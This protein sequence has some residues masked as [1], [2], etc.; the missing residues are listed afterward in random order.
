M[1]HRIFFSQAGCLLLIAATLVLPIARAGDESSS[2]SLKVPEGFEVE[3]IA[4]PPLV[5]RPIS[6]DFDDQ[7]RLY[8]TDSSGSNEEVEKQA[9]DKPHRIVRLE[10]TNGD[11]RFD[12]SVVFADKMAFPE[13]A[14]WFDGSLYVAAPPSIWKL[15]DSDGDGVA[16]RRE[17]WFQGK[18]LTHC[19]N[20]LHGPYLGLDGWIYW[21]KGA[22][23]K[24]TYEHPGRPP[25]VT[26]ASHIFRRRPGDP[27]VEPV[28]TG[29]MDNPVDVVFTPAGERIFT[30]TF[31]VHPQ[32]GL[33][34]GLI[35]AIYGGVYGKAHDVIDDHK[36]TGDLLP[37]MTHL[38]PAVP[39]GLTRYESK[40]FGEDYRDNLFACLFNLHKV[41]RHILKPNGSTFTTEDIDFLTSENPDFHPTDVIEDAD[42]SLIVVD[43]GGWYKICCPSSQLVKPDVLGAIY[44][45]RRKGAP[46]VEDPR[47]LKLAW[48]A[49]KADQ[50][51]KL[52]DDPRPAVRSRAIHELAKRGNEAIPAL[53]AA[54]KTSG[55]VEVRRNALWSLTRIEGTAARDAVRIAFEDRDD[56]VRHAACHSAGVWRDA[57]ALPQLL[58]LLQNGPAP[59]QRAAA[60][61]AGRIGDKQAVP[62]LLLTAGAPHDRILEH[63]LT[64]ALIEIDS[65]SATA[66]GLR[67]TSPR[68]RRAALIALD[69]MEHGGLK[70]EMVTPLLAS[71]DSVLRPAAWWILGHHSEWSPGLASFFGRRLADKNISG[72]ERKEFEQQLAQFARDAE[73]QALLAAI[74]RGPSSRSARLSALRAMAY[75][76]LKEMPATWIASLPDVMASQDPEV[77]HYA[78]NVARA[79]PVSPKTNAPSLSSALLRI[80]RNH[81]LSPEARLDALAA[82][83]KGLTTVDSNL[84]NFLRASIATSQSGAI[85]SAASEVVAKAKLSP[86]QLLSLTE[87]IKSTGPMELPRL[88]AAYENSNDQ[89]LGMKLI[90]AL[91]ASKARASL[92]PEMLRKAL[93]KFPGSVRKSG[94]QLLASLHMDTAQ[95]KARLEKLLLELQG[96]DVRRGQAV[97]NGTKAACSSCHTIGYLGGKV[98]PDL[99]RIGQ[100]RNERDLLESIIFPSA[101][102]VRSYEPVIVDTKSGDI[103]NGV[104]RKNASD[105]VIL[106]IDARTEARI[107]RAD[108]ADMRPGAVSIMPTGL[109]EQLTRQ[110]L[111]DLLAF[112]KQTRWGPR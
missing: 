106:A 13:G 27:L 85:R 5:D 60:E 11:G 7:G 15:T 96:G 23:G 52:L 2:L 17:E 56:S 6:A 54:L 28:M 95:Q 100:I 47:G 18:T 93:A 99:T 22:F 70:P 46:R 44:R 50:A 48:T 80:A 39:C 43:T 83:P 98:G 55:S 76:P 86:S 65:P 63:S 57:G 8:V 103:Y 30:S 88:L 40:V 84:W 112:L 35:H 16:D 24:Q 58:Q 51:G 14:L 49:M 105:E 79:L 67:A 87:S 94:D 107:P 62:Q 33:R 72:A 9:Q 91:E 32:A 78:V 4:G 41:T 42:G 73:I 26:R 3:R 68:S 12:K 20:D 59:L 104:L 29:G 38:G 36:K 75:A 31:V 37:V 77:I 102:F 45:V 34:D 10:D 19:A 1:N 111:A 108:I 53:A 110:D 21:C 92:H 90:A 69:Q 66:S 109:E 101:S 64:Y 61:A 74:A 25:L 97:F 89:E 82:L 71:N 81:I